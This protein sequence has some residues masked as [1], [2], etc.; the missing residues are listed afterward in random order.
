[1]LPGGGVFRVFIAASLTRKAA[2]KWRSRKGEARLRLMSE[3]AYK[4][5]PITFEANAVLLV[6]DDTENRPLAT[7]FC[8]IKPEWVVTAKHVVLENGLP[9]TSLSVLSYRG[10]PSRTS[11]LFLH[12]QHDLAVLRIE[13]DS[14]C[15]VPLFPGFEM[16]TGKRGLV[17]CGYAPSLSDRQAGRNTIFVNQV[18]SYERE[19]RMRDSGDESLI[20]FNA[21]WMEGGHSGGPV[22]GEGGGVVAVLIELLRL[23]EGVARARATSILALLRFLN[24]QV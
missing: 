16:H 12:P 10:E 21:P 7:G 18:E 5:N 4:G 11:I 9:R 19:G 6:H 1:M 23:D 2:Q 13:G 8:F 24:F 20:V 22:F 3:G 14:P 15:D 17:C